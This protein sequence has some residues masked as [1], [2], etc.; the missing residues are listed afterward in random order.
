[1]IV[2]SLV[3]SA[4]P[5]LHPYALIL[6]YYLLC[7]GL[8]CALIVKNTPSVDALRPYP[9]RISSL[10]P[11]ILLAG[12]AVGLVSAVTLLWEIPFELAGLNTQTAGITEAGNAAQLV[13]S[14][15]V[16]AAI[17]AVCE[18]ILFRGV[19]LS[20][21]E[22]YGTVR[23][24]LI[25]S[26]LFTLLHGS[27]IGAPAELLLGLM[28]CV[29]VI[30]TGSIWS[31]VVFHTIYNALVIVLNN[32]IGGGESTQTVLQSIGGAKGLISVAVD[33]ALF[34]LPSYYFIRALLYR[35]KTEHVVVYPPRRVRLGGGALAMLI[36]A[37][38]IAVLLCA[39]DFCQMAGVIL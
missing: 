11:V 15:V 6:G 24:A 29:I 38:V 34:A 12:L 36:A 31:G 32:A 39:A 18:E 35:A 20:A 23:A 21:F 13:L 14:V 2:L 27:V 1:M 9:P 3:A 16:N 10:L 26:V 19:I 8:P 17:P 33:I 28:L 22:G 30:T 4:L 25:S 5:N 7:I 37:I